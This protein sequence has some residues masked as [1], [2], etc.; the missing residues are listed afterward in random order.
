MD[1]APTELKLEEYRMIAEDMHDFFLEQYTPYVQGTIMMD[2]LNPNNLKFAL[3]YI[4]QSVATAHR[5]TAANMDWE[6]VYEWVETFALMGQE[7]LRRGYSTVSDLNLGFRNFM[8]DPFVAHEKE[9]WRW[10]MELQE[11]RLNGIDASQLRLYARNPTVV[12]DRGRPALKGKEN[13]GVGAMQLRTDFYALTHPFAQARERQRQALELSS[14]FPSAT[15]DNL[16]SFT[17]KGP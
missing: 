11:K 17:P 1:A 16:L 8:V 9:L 12:D 10:V 6:V 14:F 13:K 15:V 7:A 3:Y 4:A 5:S 2:F